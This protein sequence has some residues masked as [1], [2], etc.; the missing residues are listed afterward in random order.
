MAESAEWVAKIH[1]RPAGEPL[2]GGAPNLAGDKGF[3]NVPTQQLAKRTLWLKSKVDDLFR[4]GSK[5]DLTA[6]AILEVGSFGLGGGGLPLT[7]GNVNSSYATGFYFG[8]AGL[9]ASASAGSNPFPNE[10]GAFT[11]EVVGSSGLGDVQEWVVQR[12]T[13]IAAGNNPIVRYRTKSNSALGWGAWDAIWT[14]VA[15]PS[16]LGQSGWQKLPE[17]LILQWGIGSALAADEASG[18]TLNPF[19]ITFTAN[20]WHVIATDRG[21]AA[22]A[23][24]VGPPTASNFKAVCRRNDGVYIDSNFSYLAIGR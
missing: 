2:T 10:T 8:Y 18:G 4:Q 3:A 23:V 6:R 24:S 13:L 16:L 20:C 7:N 17:G 19:P 15:A 12:A 11:L 9:H 1:Q 5:S 21:A 22:L 14:N